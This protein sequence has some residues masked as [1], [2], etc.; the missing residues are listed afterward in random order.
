VGRF[1]QGNQLRCKDY[2]DLSHL[3]LMKS[4]SVGMS[5]L[6]S[7]LTLGILRDG[8]HYLS[9]VDSC[10]SGTQSHKHLWKYF[11]GDQTL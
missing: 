7:R 4:I 2:C 10:R 3:A 1:H 5:A 8:L 9:Q 11:R 6:E